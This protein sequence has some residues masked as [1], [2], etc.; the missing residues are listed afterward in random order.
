MAKSKRKTLPK[1]FDELL[2][3][4]DLDALK[5]LFDKV[6][7]D[8]HGGTFKRSA[9]A[10]NDCPDDLSRWLVEQGADLHSPDRYGETPLHSRS[11][12][13]QGNT[14]V[15]LELGAEV[16]HK[17]GR[18]ETPLHLAAAVGNT[19]TAD[20]LLEYGADPYALN[21]KGQSPLVFALE[22]CSNVK[23]DRMA[24]M[25]ELL[26][27]A[28]TSPPEKKSFVGRIF[29]QSNGK[30]DVITPE[31][32]GMVEEIG[33]TF[34]F[35]R[36]DFDPDSV[37]AVSTALDRLYELFAVQPIPKRSLHDGQSNIVAK[38]LTWQDKHQE[39]WEMLV[40]SI[41][42]ASTVQGEVIR[43]SGRISD[44]LNRNG[45]V[46]WGSD[47][48]KMADALL[49]HFRSGNPLPPQDL[50]FAAK[51]ISDAKSLQGDESVELCR[52]AVDWVAL[53]PD[54]INLEKPSYRL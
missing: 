5:S 23:I 1:N 46:N 21:S 22:K 42:A 13:W 16:N 6:D 20:L 11:G 17:G 15:L 49:V 53:N 2:R 41:G 37:E 26:L 19:A 43:I 24:P 36:A 18:G 33:R 8:A 51:C 12:H 44:E 25:A 45:G 14:A 31:M 10:F 32:K 52:L 35:H 38:S 30:D 4:G 28:M 29:G 7:V 50:D 54:P 47:H 34:E 48:R 40:P 3:S 9:L 39:L 27:N